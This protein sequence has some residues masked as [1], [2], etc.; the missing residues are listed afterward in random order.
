MQA[1]GFDFTVPHDVEFFA[2]FPTEANADAVAMMFVADR[3]AGDLL[4]NIE[5]RPSH[6]GGMSL[7]LVRRLRLTHA[8]VTALER[9]F[10]QR[11]ELQGGALD[12]WGVLR[13]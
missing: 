6:R 9:L 4:V 11:T 10:R 12:G 2:A 13:A 5:T 8:G 1:S 7:Q 3:D